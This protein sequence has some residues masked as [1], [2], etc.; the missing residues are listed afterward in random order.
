MKLKDACEIALAC[1][2]STTGEAVLNV[3]L[4]AISLFDY[5]EIPTELQELDAE[6]AQVGDIPIVD[7]MGDKET[8]L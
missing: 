8:L 6:L 5:G 2:L 1:D 3:R 4:H 7:Y